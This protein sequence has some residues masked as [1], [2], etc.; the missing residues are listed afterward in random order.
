MLPIF[1]AAALTLLFSW[2]NGSLYLGGLTAS[3]VM[4]FRRATLLIA[5]AMVLGVWAEGWKMSPAL[6]TG[7]G[8]VPALATALII[9]FASNLLNIPVSLSN[10]AVATLAGSSLAL[11][12]NINAW[13]LMEVALAWMLAPFAAMFLAWIIYIVF[14][15]L[16]S[17][18]GLLVLDLVNRLSAYLISF[19]S[20]YALAANNIG[21]ILNM[22]P[23]DGVGGLLLVSAAAAAGVLFFTR[24]AS[25][26]M[27]E[28]LVV[29]SPQRVFTSVASA[30]IVLWILTQFGIPGALT[31]TLLGG[32]AG[33]IASS[34][35]A[36]INVKLVKRFV[37][38]WIL[39]TLLSVPAGYCLAL[40]LR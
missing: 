39:T 22:A 7:G 29:L 14:R 1:L 20:A 15:A 23:G 24:R 38:A 16:L 37:A 13:F 28:R 2:N 40:L 11:G 5:S 27:G 34:P 4:R 6:L 30:S 35:L 10:I 31:Q 8:Y 36:I 12:L 32:L 19:Y 3:G 33:S 17:R 26:M 9:F 21:F 25:F 18:V